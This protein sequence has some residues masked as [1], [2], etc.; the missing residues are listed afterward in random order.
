[1]LVCPFGYFYSGD[2]TQASAQP[3]SAVNRDYEVEVTDRS[4]VYSCYRLFYAETGAPDT[5]LSATHR[6]W[7]DQAQLASFEDASEYARLVEE[8]QSRIYIDNNGH[9]NSI[10]SSADPVVSSNYCR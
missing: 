3:Y 9:D 2:D 5:W 10:G 8:I 1:M 4:P 7:Q 6:C